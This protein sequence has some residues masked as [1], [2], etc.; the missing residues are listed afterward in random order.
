MHS[1]VANDSVSIGSDQTVQGLTNQI[2]IYLPGE[3]IRQEMPKLIAF[4]YITLYIL[5]Y[6]YIFMSKVENILLAQQKI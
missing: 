4:P 1:I 2:V 6:I 5:Y 3:V